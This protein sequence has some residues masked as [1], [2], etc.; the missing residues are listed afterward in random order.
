MKFYIFMCFIA[1]I[2]LSGNLL[3][4]KRN[5]EEDLSKPAKK[6]KDEAAA[7]SVPEDIVL[8]YHYKL[9]INENTIDLKSIGDEK[10]AIT[11][12]N[13]QPKNAF[14]DRIYFPYNKIV[15]IIVLEPQLD[16]FMA[17]IF[18]NNISIKPL[19]FHCFKYIVQSFVWHDIND[20]KLFLSFCDGLACNKTIEKL[21]L[22]LDNKKLASFVSALI[23]NES[24]S[25]LCITY[26]IENSDHKCADSFGRAI[27]GHKMLKS[28]TFKAEGLDDIFVKDMIPYFEKSTLLEINMLEIDVL[29]PDTAMSL[30]DLLR[31][32]NGIISLR[33]RLTDYG[34]N[35]KDDRFKY[36]QAS[37]NLVGKLAELLRKNLK[38]QKF[39]FGAP[40]EKLKNRL[41]INVELNKSWKKYGINLWLFREIEKSIETVPDEFE[42]V[43]RISSGKLE[44]L[45]ISLPKEVRSQYLHG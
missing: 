4:M 20:E 25:S 1:S 34:D 5:A 39:Y 43:F 3:A 30:C 19:F 23:A 21:T 15:Q 38:L 42:E 16:L 28:I 12:R 29:Y 10:H 6:V 26:D 7:V 36:K 14:F 17:E 27:I 35:T 37:F 2:A 18:R 11:W 45:I 31:D 32:N 33:F 41:D 40:P 9:S 13:S 24:I 22:S 44:D 8:Y